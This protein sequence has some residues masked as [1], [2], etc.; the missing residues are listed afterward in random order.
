MNPVSPERSTTP[1]LPLAGTAIAL[2]LLLPSIPIGAAEKDE[3]KPE[4]PKIAVSVPFVAFAGST[5]VLTLRGQNLTN[6]SALRFE[7]A[8]PNARWSIR[9]AAKTEVPKDADAKR[10]GDTQLTVELTLPDDA[11]PGDARIVVSSPA[12]ESEPHPI[13]IMARSA[14]EDE[15]EPNGGF[16]Q[17]QPLELGRTLAGKIGES[18]DVDVFRFTGHRGQRVNIAVRAAALGSLL[19]SVVTLHDAE[20]HTLAINDDRGSNDSQLE[21]R[22]K[23]DG[24]YLVS[25]IDAHDRGGPLHGYLLAV[26]SS[27]PGAR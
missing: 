6:A 10:A 4:P 21:I 1:T 2:T 9:A 23:A 22:L 15:R 12:G 27:T 8:L 19:D 25:V 20:G 13:A 14:L 11:P 7:P 16:K 5:N 3:K 24:P 26:T 18:G 17:A